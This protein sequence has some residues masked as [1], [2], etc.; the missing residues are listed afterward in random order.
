MKYEGM[1]IRPPSEARSLLLQISVGC[2]HNKCTFCPTYKGEK[3][4]IKTFDEIEEDIIE[5]SGYGYIEKIFLCD[6]DALILPMRKLVPVLESINTHIKGVQRIGLYANAKSIL[7]KT[8]EELAQL[9]DLGVKIAYLGLETGNDDILQEIE[10]GANSLQ[11][12]EAGQKIKEAGITLSVTVLL[13]IGGKA[14][15][16]E[17]ARDTARVLTEIDPD[18]VGA[19]TVMVVPGTALYE[20]QVSGR[21]ELP[22]TFGFLEELGV[23]VAQSNFTDCF[24]T[25][26]HASN[27]LPIRARMP[28]E[29]DETVRLIQ[30]VITSSNKKVLT[31][32]YLR[33]L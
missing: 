19:L 28:Q 3:F 32:E 30:Q 14:R 31:P 1:V 5:A 6:G 22:D 26:N 27:Y 25:S 24:F 11:M 9:R 8:P 29:K 23:M 12:I 17:H 33:G 21:F 2:S 10:K 16:M 13:G 18:Y 7:R 15:G 20:E 4:R